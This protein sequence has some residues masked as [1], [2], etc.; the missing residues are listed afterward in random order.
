LVELVEGAEESISPKVPAA[1][2]TGVGRRSQAAA[3]AIR[4]AREI[5]GRE[6]GVREGLGW[7]R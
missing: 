5:E 4:V 3:A 6:R 7:V 1:V 2:A